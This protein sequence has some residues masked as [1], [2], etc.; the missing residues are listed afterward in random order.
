MRSYFK[1]RRNHL[2]TLAF[3]FWLSLLPLPVWGQEKDQVTQK[4]F[5]T[6][7][8][9]L[10]KNGVISFE[11]AKT[12]KWSDS[13]QP[14]A[15]AEEMPSVPLEEEDHKEGLFEEP[16]VAEQTSEFVTKEQLEQLK[17]HLE[18]LQ[19]RIDK[20]LDLMQTD[21][22]INSREIQ[23][24]ETTGID[25]LK[26]QN[27]K[28]SWAERIEISGD[29]RLRLQKDLFDEGNADILR[30][31]DPT[32]LMNTTQDRDR[33]RA[34]ARLAIK[35][36]LVDPREVNVGKV[37]AGLRISSGSDDDPVS[38]N[39]TL[40]DTFNKDDALFDRY[41]L[42]WQY[43][44][45]L[46]I[47]GRIP[48]ISLTGGR[49][50][51]PWFTS[52]LV[53]DSDV[54]LEGLAFNL[55]SDTLAENGWHLFLTAGAFPLQ[56]VALSDDDKW[57][58]AGQVGLSVQ[59]FYGVDFKLG[60]AYYDY[61]NIIGRENDPPLPGIFDFTAPGFQQMG[62]TLIDIDPTSDIKT[63]LAS[64][65]KIVDITSEVDL[66]FFHPVHILLEAGYVQNIGFDKADVIERTGNPNIDE[67]TSG[68]RFGLKV[69]YPAIINVG[70]WNASFYYK[71][72]EAD[73]VLDAFTDSD[74]HL[75][76]TNAKGWIAGLEYGLFKN[77]W[78]TA[79]WLSTDEIE[80]VP[81][82]VDTLQLDINARF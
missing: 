79:R 21:T 40:G 46:P 32:T 57:L 35:A 38:T 34:R 52:D 82:A 3:F 50:A 68:Y 67:E 64:E 45:E 22:R 8:E 28:S 10:I 51:N 19:D 12:L 48:R 17:D 56:E 80:G 55:Q 70:D 7:I 66:S 69:G 72:L 20:K 5:N 18:Q 36:N 62:N 15:Q 77:I 23:R 73:A 71:Y 25:P 44:P 33:Y 54:N 65:Y 58:Y 63:A 41:Y 74:F 27:I 60:V 6:I 24:L 13:D 16:D 76:G 9:L 61:Q 4:D 47:W 26:E 75:G 53:W 14:A 29:L 1:C 42:K 11:K 31:D 43:K 39:E 49:M 81:L 2:F 78:L 59:P 30:P 37:E